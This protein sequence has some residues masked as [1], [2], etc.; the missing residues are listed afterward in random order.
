MSKQYV[1]SIHHCDIHTVCIWQQF[2]FVGYFWHLNRSKESFWKKLGLLAR[3][4]YICIYIYLIAKAILRQKIL[5]DCCWRWHV[6]VEVF[7]GK[8]AWITTEKIYFGLMVN[9]SIIWTRPSPGINHLKFPWLLSFS[10]H[11]FGC[12]FIR[13]L[14]L[15]LCI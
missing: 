6:A 4:E 2:G 1:C 8:V 10:F 11:F 5:W 3:Y 13:V 12:L 14:Y 9:A 15:L 7:W